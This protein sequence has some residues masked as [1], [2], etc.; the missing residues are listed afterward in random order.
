MNTYEQK[1]SEF[2]NQKAIAIAGVSRNPQGSVGNGIYRKFK[3][4]GYNIY[5]VNPN[6][7]VI[8][9]D[10]CFPNLKSIPEKIDAVFIATSPAV[11]TEI[12]KQSIEGGVKTIW[13]HRG[14]GNGSF[15]EE[16]AKL[17]EENGLKVIRGG[18]PMMYISKV[19]PFHKMMHFFMKL[20]G[21][22][23]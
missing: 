14:M 19:D 20:F 12:V 3:D 9:G 1:V 10:K 5:P 22:L 23:K 7:E 11:S 21:K 15:S 16:A 2:L 13:F 8:E 6:A 4:S 18:C 17:G